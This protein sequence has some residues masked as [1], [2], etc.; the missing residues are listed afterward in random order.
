MRICFICEGSYPYVRGGVSSWI[1]TIIT[2]NPDLEF[3]IFSI[4]TTEAEMSEYK[5]EIPDNVKEIKTFYISSQTIL[6]NVK[7]IKLTRMELAILDNLLL[8]NGDDIDWKATLDFMK[9]HR[10]HLSDI[11]MSPQFYE[12]VLKTYQVKY[13]NLSFN[14][15]LWNMRSMYHPFMKLLSTSDIEADIYHPVSTGYAGILGAIFSKIHEKPL[16]LSE[17]GIYTREREEDIIK[18]QWLKGNFKDIWISFFKRLSYIAYHQAEKV[19]TLFET[20][21]SLQI[22]LGCDDH[23]IEVIPNGVD[24]ETLGNLKS[25]SDKSRQYFNIG[26]VL[27]IVPIKDVKTMIFAFQIAKAQIPNARLCIMGN[28]DESPGYYQECLDIV[29]HLG[30]SD[31]IFTG[32][33]DIKEH[34]NEFDLLLLTSI[35]EGQPLAVIEGMAARKPF[36]CTNVGSCQELLL[37]DDG[38]DQAGFIVPIMGVEEL[39]DKIVY[40]A[41]H[42]DEIRQMG[43]NGYNRVNRFYRSEIFLNRFKEIYKE[44]APWQA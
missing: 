30:I 17:H 22:E 27:R 38:F 2:A 24:T 10:E 28:Y 3:A 14:D 9:E 21:K 41:N 33:V 19:T 42:P 25:R 29:A 39:A 43:L 23:K 15:F 37:S 4:A 26:T 35:S 44:M 34:L 12:L 8:G 16:L 18:S 20:N 13:G 11:L 5:Y 36:I 1:N 31:I 40:C 32:Q 7:K 6:E